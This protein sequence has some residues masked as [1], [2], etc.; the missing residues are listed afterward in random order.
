MT[1]YIPEWLFHG[2]LLM[3]PTETPSMRAKQGL[4]SSRGAVLRAL[5]RRAKDGRCARISCRAAT[6]K[7]RRLTETADARNGAAWRPPPRSQG[8]QER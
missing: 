3:E 8:Q 6:T 2:R 7:R 1:M 4:E 5:A